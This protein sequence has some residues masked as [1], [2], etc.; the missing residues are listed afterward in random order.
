MIYLKEE[1][2]RAFTSPFFFLSFGVMFVCLL[3]YSIPGW[4]FAGDLELEWKESA[5]QLSVGGIFFGGMMLLMPF[6]AAVSH[7][8]SQVDEIATSMLRWRVLRG[9]VRKYAYVK[10]VACALSAACSIALAF[11]LHAVVWNII[12]LPVDPSRYPGH[13]IGFADWCLYNQWYKICYGLPMY[14]E[15]TLGIAFSAAAWA[16]VALAA[17]VWIPDRLLVITVPSCIYHI[18]QVQLPYYFFKVYVPDPATLYNDAL[19]LQSALECILAYAVVLALSIA[20]YYAGLE[21]RARNA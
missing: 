6:C 3:G 19:T 8:V 18:W 7:A 12:A 21:R 20:L 2:K 5:L 13:E 1:L 17:A 4:F 10:I 11:A 9:S 16:V 15:M 14:V